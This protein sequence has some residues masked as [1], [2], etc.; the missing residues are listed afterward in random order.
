MIFKNAMSFKAKI[1]QLAKEKG[2][3][4]QQVQQNFL[5]EVF[6]IKL[7]KS[8]YKENF[9]IKGGYLIG[10]IVGLDMRSTMD[11]DTTIKGFELTAEVLSD[12]TKDIIENS[13]RRIFYINV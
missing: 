9:I 3:T 6:L 12:I 10:G 13:N 4:T 2:L 1:K 5:I 11:L 7:S 8:K